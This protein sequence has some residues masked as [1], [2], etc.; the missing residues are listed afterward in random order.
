M[1][2]RHRIDFLLLGS[3]I[4]LVC[5]GIVTLYAQ[6]SVMDGGGED[7]WFK[8]C[9]F[10]VLLA[11]PVC[12]VLRRMNYS[13]LGDYAVPLY[14]F[15]ILLLVLTLVPFIGASAKG[16]RSWIRLGPVGFQTSEL[17]KLTTIII[18]AK[19]L[20]LKERD[21]ERIPTLLLPFALTLLPMLLIVIQ[22]DFG[23][24]F[25]FAPI[26]LTMLFVAGAD[27]YHIGS[28]VIFFGTS[29]FIPLYIEY[30]RITLVEPLLAHLSELGKGNLLPAVR[31]LRRDVW[32]YLDDGVIPAAV[33]S[34]EDRTYLANVLTNEGLI[35]S[36]REAAR[37][38]RY[39]AGGF[40][41]RLLENE[42]LLVIV[43]GLLAIVAIGLFLVRFTQ[44]AS[45]ANLRKYYIPLGVI[46]GSLLSAAA[47]Q[48]TFSFKYYQVVRVT[49][50]VNPD[51]FPRDEAYQIRASKAAIG[52]GRFLGRGIFQG[53]MTMGD[54]P[55]V[56][57]SSTDF[58][59]TAWS[60]RTGF[61]G[62][63][64]AIM[65]MISI[66]L[67][68]LLVSFEA[69]DRFGSLLAAGVSAMFFYHIFFN[70]G[71]ALGLLPVTGLP[72]SFMSY[73]RSHLLA[74]LAALG[75]LLSVHR[76]RFAN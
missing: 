49:A 4:L 1:E 33:Q 67:R 55:L 35:T 54:R 44:G 11:L 13:F 48:S 42:W 62:G 53:D 5:A 41:L 23:G 14:L 27:I 43:G 9:L 60:E 38:V 70:A 29:I 74:C 28:V 46:G 26:L 8:Q 15:S 24:A 10:F 32:N 59:F 19:Y 16:A 3:A 2:R 6:E 51:K 72:L 63:F 47:V 65:L 12:L 17:A 76:R 21:I 39:E 73:G 58:I 7:R 37:D 64:I 68:G 25:T 30:N 69:R 34:P 36:L 52:S 31:I 71:I 22:P 57:E 50:F 20:E 18:L 61:I 45:M 40:V 66:P 56:P 75:M